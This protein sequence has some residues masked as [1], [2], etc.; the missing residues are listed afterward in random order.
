MDDPRDMRPEQAAEA[1]TILKP[2]HVI[3]YHYG[4]TGPMSLLL[5]ASEA[6]KEFQGNVA[7][8]D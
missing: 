8:R 7:K 3:P 5:S 2:K 4:L 6:G 1:Y